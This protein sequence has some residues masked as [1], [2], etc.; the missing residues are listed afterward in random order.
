MQVYSCFG[1][2]V[3]THTHINVAMVL[4][5]SITVYSITNSVSLCHIFMLLTTITNKINCNE[6]RQSAVKTSWK[7][8]TS[9]KWGFKNQEPELI[10]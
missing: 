2:Y 4:I 6:S 10:Y 3:S 7:T 5:I 9:C 1:Y 8:N